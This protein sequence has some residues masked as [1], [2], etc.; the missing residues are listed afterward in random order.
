MGEKV[1]PPVDYLFHMA[2]CNSRLKTGWCTGKAKATVGG[3]GA[4]SPEEQNAIVSVIKRNE[5]LE[6]A[7]RQRVGRLVDKLDRIKE[8][9]VDCGPNQCR[10][11]GQMFRFLRAPK[12]IC[13]DCSYPVCTKCSIDLSVKPPRR[14]GQ[15]V[16]ILC[17]VCTLT[18][19]IWKKSGAWFY[20]GIPQYDLP[21]RQP[22][23]NYRPVANIRL[24]GG[25]STSSSDEEE[26]EEEAAMH[27][28]HQGTSSTTSSRWILDPRMRL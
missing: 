17:K 19:E 2:A 20:K 15:N 12:V 4:L 14:G 23:R 8:R 27:H 18:R 7:E 11:C 24:R 21:Q 10:L 26:D 25:T 5:A 3:G 28:H 16:H 13:E 1:I 22:V 9:I 6:T